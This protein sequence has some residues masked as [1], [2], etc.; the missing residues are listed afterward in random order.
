MRAGQVWVGNVARLRV[1]VSHQ[2][3]GKHPHVP[4]RGV[5]LRTPFKDEEMETWVRIPVAC[6][7]LAEAPLLVCCFLLGAEVPRWGS[8]GG[9]WVPGPVCPQSVGR[10]SLWGQNL[11]GMLAPKESS[12]TVCSR[13][14]PKCSW[15]ICVFACTSLNVRHWALVRCTARPPAPP[16]LATASR[17]RRGA[18]PSG[19][20]C[21]CTGSLMSLSGL[22]RDSWISFMSVLGCKPWPGVAPRG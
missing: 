4:S 10:P 21:V 8:Q 5:L 17:M 18:R 11:V 13:V 6:Q 22:G 20:G 3:L 16:A 19:L 7:H 12:C 2:A 15:L 1:L 14:R 9:V